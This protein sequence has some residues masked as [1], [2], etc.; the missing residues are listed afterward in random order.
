MPRNPSPL[1]IRVLQASSHSS[2]SSSLPLASCGH[3]ITLQDSEL[4]SA[5]R[6]L[7]LFLPF[8]PKTQQRSLQRQAKLLQRLLKLPQQPLRLPQQSQKLRQQLLRLQQP[9]QKLQRQPRKQLQ[10]LP[11]QLLQQQKLH[12]LRLLLTIQP[13]QLKVLR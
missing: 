9:Q 10:L 4:S 12:R 8:L 5:R 13:K 1:R 3:L 6:L 11:K 2:L 7:R